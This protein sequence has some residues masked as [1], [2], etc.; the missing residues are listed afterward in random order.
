M[1]QLIRHLSRLAVLGCIAS[2]AAA[3]PAADVTFHRD[4]LPILQNRCQT[5]H[6]PGDIGPMSLLTY[7]EGDPVGNGGAAL[8]AALTV[9][10]KKRIYFSYAE[11]AGGH[12]EALSR[13]LYHQRT[14]DW[15]DETLAMIG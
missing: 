7:A 14:Y 11:G 6:R 12:C 3:A 4:V 10:R 5:C 9:S 1:A 2:P 15:L 13:T 8:L